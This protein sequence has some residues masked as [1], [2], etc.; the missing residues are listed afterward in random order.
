M[1]R[2]V[3]TKLSSLSS[4]TSDLLMYVQ[5]TYGQTYNKSMNKPGKVDNPARGQLNRE[6]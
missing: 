1:Q 4:S 6:N 2:A 5:C 3:Q